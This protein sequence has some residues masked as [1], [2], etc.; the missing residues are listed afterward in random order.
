MPSAS[1]AVSTAFATSASTRA[2]W[3][4]AAATSGAASDWPARA[5]RS[6]RIWPA[7]ASRSDVVISACITEDWRSRRTSVSP[8][9]D[10]G[11]PA[12]SAVSERTVR[13]CTVAFRSAA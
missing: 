7:S 13:D 9:A 8:R 5:T 4:S 12:L 3:D 2:R 10:T 1:T 6:L 11:T